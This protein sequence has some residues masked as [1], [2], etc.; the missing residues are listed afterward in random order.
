ML[1]HMLYTLLC[2]DMLCYAVTLRPNGFLQAVLK[3]FYF[4]KLEASTIH[5]KSCKH[6]SPYILCDDLKR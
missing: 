3:T 6:T 2:Y 1:C 5:Q 4:L